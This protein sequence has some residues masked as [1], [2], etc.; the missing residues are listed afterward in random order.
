MVLSSSCGLIPRPTDSAPCGSKSSSSTLRPYSASAA[1]RLIVD[2]VLPT[3]PFWLH[4][5]MIR[6]GPWPV[7]GCGTG[8][9]RHRPTGRPEAADDEPVEPVTDVEAQVV[10]LMRLGCHERVHSSVDVGGVGDA[11][12]TRGEPASPDHRSRRPR[13]QRG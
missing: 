4:I 7:S 2:V 9:V 8:N 5:A 11:G 10:R 6:A 1:P 12:A 3:P 13:T